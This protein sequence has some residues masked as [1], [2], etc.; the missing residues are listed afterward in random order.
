[1]SDVLLPY[2]R[3]ELS[4]IRRAGEDFARRNPAVASRL[5]M[6]RGD[7]Q[8]PHVER[9][10]EA[11]AFLTA[12]IRHKLDDEFPE[13]V[14]AVLATLYPHC[15]AP[16]PSMA[17]AQFT[18]SRE[19]PDLFTGYVVPSHSLLETETPQG[20]CRFRTV[21]PVMC[22]PFEVVSAALRPVPYVVGGA[23]SP[24]GGAVASVH[25]ELRCYGSEFTFAQMRF[26]THTPRPS[27]LLPHEPF[28]PRPWGL[29][30]FLH[31]DPQHGPSLYELLVNQLVG[32]AVSGREQDPNV[33]YLPA[34]ALRPVGFESDESILP[35]S[36]RAFFGHQLLTEY[37]LLP[38]KFLFVDLVGLTPATLRHVGNRLHL[39]LLLKA[40]SPEL[41]QSVSAD[42]FRLG[43]TPIVNL[44]TQTAEPVRMTHT[45]SEYRIVP[46]ARR[47]SLHEVYSVDSVI[48]SSPDGVERTYLPFYAGHHPS[49]SV[50]P[51]EGTGADGRDQAYYY[52]RRAPAQ[53]QA[54]AAAPQPPSGTDVFLAPVDLGFSPSHAANSTLHVQTTCFNR[55]IPGKLQFGGGQLRFE[56]SAGGPVGVECLTRPT[57]TRRPELGRDATWKLVSHLNLNYLSL[58]G[59][60]DGATSLREILR[61]H[62]LRQS[63]DTASRIA[64]LLSVSAA[65][66]VARVGSTQG[67]P[68]AGGFCRGTE[69]T[70]VLEE[71]AFPDRGAFLFASVLERFLGLYSSVNSFTQ[72]VA[73]LRQR[74]RE[75]K[76]WPPRA[77]ERALL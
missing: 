72:L 2:Y 27:H 16:A 59:R 60:H 77:G 74:E 3:R 75:L 7:H 29:R 50:T 20:P 23:R 1:M 58:S 12:R 21:L 34:N 47:P 18:V 45:H 40:S 30:F 14:N 15:L 35:R 24:A 64:G 54:A 8:D 43:C 36:Q 39:D 25:I 57:P 71:D 33:A 62:D 22:Y 61:L 11:F 38:E 65:R 6:G 42:T 19:Q 73:R 10:I 48:A 13:L 67:Q 28:D 52:I 68:V 32:V 44:Y 70:V 17:V 5:G 51:Q 41:E 53:D 63:P 66:T 69:V 49:A 55:D 76:R 4:Y 9:L 56:L 46:D 31:A 26:P 37:F